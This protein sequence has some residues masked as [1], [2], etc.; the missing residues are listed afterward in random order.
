MPD[1]TPT[2]DRVRAAAQRALQSLDD[3]IADTTDPGVEAL[4]AR[5]ELATALFN[6]SLAPARQVLG[7]TD[8]QPTTV[9]DGLEPVQL[10][11]GLDDVMYGDDDTATVLLSGPGGEPYWVEMDPERTAAL[12]EALAGPEAQPATDQ[13]E[14]VWATVPANGAYAQLMGLTWTRC[15][16][17]DQQPATDQPDEAEAH[18]T[19]VT[20][21]GEMQESDGLWGYL[22]A[23]H[24]RAVV[25]KRTAQLQKRFPAWNDGTPIRTRLV[26]KTTTYTVAADQPDTETE[27]ASPEQPTAATADDRCPG[28][29][30]PCMTDESHDPAP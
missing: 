14:H 29:C 19:E 16:T 4:G 8:Q 22:R 10:R 25:E 6:T 17:C 24:D 2:T 23:D 26:R 30:I 21:I 11:W 27:A 13:H 9:L 1:T 7:T 5:H 28:F 15:T 18:P 20:W 12:R 3:L